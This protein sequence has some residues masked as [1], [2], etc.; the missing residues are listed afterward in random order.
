MT[1]RS[2]GTRIIA[3]LLVVSLGTTACYSQR[4]IGVPRPGEAVGDVTRVT[5][6]SGEQIDLRG[7]QALWQDSAIVYFDE[8]VRTQIPREEIREITITEISWMRTTGLMIGI[9]A[10]TAVVAFT[11]ALLQLRER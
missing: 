2:A 3:L 9:A 11:Y 4:Q 8:S 5:L 10:G 6:E 1:E 7:Q